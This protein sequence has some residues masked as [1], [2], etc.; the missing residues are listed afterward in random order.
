MYTY[1]PEKYPVAIC[2]HCLR[3]SDTLYNMNNVH[4]VF[5]VRRCMLTLY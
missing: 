3:Y 2:R 5:N 1:T 4:E